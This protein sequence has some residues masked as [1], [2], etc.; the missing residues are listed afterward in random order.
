MGELSISES[1][2]FYGRMDHDSI[3][4]VVKSCAFYLQTSNDEGMAMSVVEAM[5]YGLLPVVT[6]VGEIASYCKDMRNSLLIRSDEDIIKK[7]SDVIIDHERYS[8]MASRSMEYWCGA[9]LFK[10]DF[11]ENCNSIKNTSK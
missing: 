3:R 2:I 1:V 8:E 5:Q 11:I 6:P 4:E 10:D 7:L 9:K